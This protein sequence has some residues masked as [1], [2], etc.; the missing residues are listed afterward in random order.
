L[1]YSTTA[2]CA[3]S[4]WA[5]IAEQRLR[6]VSAGGPCTGCAPAHRG[7]GWA[8]RDMQMDVSCSRGFGRPGIG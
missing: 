2:A 1:D 5:F 3:V 7:A 8:W 6:H 4:E